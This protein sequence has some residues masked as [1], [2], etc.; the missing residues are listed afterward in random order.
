MAV[1]G[2]SELDIASGVFVHSSSGVCVYVAG[3]TF[4]MLPDQT[5]LGGTIVD[6]FL[7][8]VGRPTVKESVENNST[9]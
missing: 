4:G 3:Q 1:V 8:Y 5:S 6:V 9:N 2:S 7:S